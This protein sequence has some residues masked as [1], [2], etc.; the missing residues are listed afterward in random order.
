MD[1]GRLLTGSP[2]FCLG[3]TVN[4]VQ[5]R[6][7]PQLQFKQLTTERFTHHLLLTA[8]LPQNPALLFFAITQVRE[9]FS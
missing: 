8:P 6:H 2:F 1:G 4:F 5:D 3:R 7:R 9:P